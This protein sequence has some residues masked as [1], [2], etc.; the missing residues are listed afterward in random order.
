MVT[1]PES[2]PM[3]ARDMT[4]SMSEN[5]WL[6][7]ISKE[8]SRCVVRAVIVEDVVDCIG[9]SIDALSRH[10]ASGDGDRKNAVCVQSAAD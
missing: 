6:F 1:V 5:P 10:D 9:V 3:I 7:V 4:S 2:V 8:S